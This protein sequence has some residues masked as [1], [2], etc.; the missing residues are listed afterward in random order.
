MHVNRTPVILGHFYAL[1]KSVSITCN[2]PSPANTTVTS[3]VY[4]KNSSA[5]TPNIA[6]SQLTTVNG[7]IGKELINTW[8]TLLVASAAA[9]FGA[10]VL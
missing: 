2:D 4:G 3:Y 5:M 9:M 7:A 6:F 1:V 10:L 8:A